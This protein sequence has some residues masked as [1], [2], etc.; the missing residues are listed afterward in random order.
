MGDSGTFSSPVADMTA[1]P[2]ATTMAAT[3][4]DLMDDSG[5]TG[6][7]E[8]TVT[9]AISPTSSSRPSTSQ[10]E[11]NTDT[12]SSVVLRDSFTDPGM[13]LTQFPMQHA[14]D[15]LPGSHVAM[16]TTE[17]D[18]LTTDQFVSTVML[19]STVGV[20]KNS[21]GS[22]SISAPVGVSR[23][24]EFLE[25]ASSELD[26][27]LTT[28]VSMPQ[29]GDS[30][31]KAVK[32]DSSVSS[33]VSVQSTHSD[34]LVIDPLS[35]TKSSSVSVKGIIQTTSLSGSS[36][37]QAH[38]S[39]IGLVPQ[40]SRPQP[41]ATSQ[42]LY[43]TYTPA[44]TLYTSGNTGLDTSFMQT[45]S[46][47]LPPPTHKPVQTSSEGQSTILG[48]G[49]PD[50]ILY[51][52]VPAIG[53]G[54][55]IFLLICII[56]ICR[57]KHK[58]S[59]SS[60]SKA[61]SSD[62]WVNH[63]QADITL[64]TR[65]PGSSL[66]DGIPFKPNIG[67]TTYE[68]VF[69]FNGSHG[70][71]L[72]LKQGDLV[73]VSRK[74]DN[75]WWQGSHGGMS[76]WFPSNY[77][78][79]APQDK[80]EED[81]EVLMHGEDVTSFN[82]G[83]ATPTNLRVSTLS[84][85]EIEAEPIYCK[86]QH[87]DKQSVCS[88]GSNRSSS[89]T[90]TKPEANHPGYA[91]P[92][93]QKHGNSAEHS[94]PHG[95]PYVAKFPFEARNLGE[96][97]IN[98]GD[99]IHCREEGKHGWIRGTNNN[100]NK[101]GWCPASYVEKVVHEVT[102]DPASY[103]QLEA[104]TDVVERQDLVGIVHH[105]IHSFDGEKAGDLQFEHG[106]YI[107][108]FQVLENGWW[109]GSK[110]KT[111]G[112]FPGSHVEMIDHPSSSPSPSTVCSESQG[113]L[114]TSHELSE[115]VQDI[116]GP[117]TPTKHK[118][119]RKAPP[120]PLKIVN[121]NFKPDNSSTTGNCNVNDQNLKSDHSKKAHAPDSKIPGL[122]GSKSLKIPRPKVAPPPPP[123]RQDDKPP[124]DDSVKDGIES[125][126][127]RID[128]D[129]E[130][131]SG[132]KQK[133]KPALP[134]RF[135][136]PKL[137][138]VP[139]GEVK[140]PDNRE[141]GNGDVKLRAPPP[142]KPLAPKLGPI[143]AKLSAPKSHED[144][145]QS[146]E[147]E[148]AYFH[149]T[150]QRRFDPILRQESSDDNIDR[151]ESPPYRS[152]ASFGNTFGK[153]PEEKIPI[154]SSFNHVPKEPASQLDMESREN[155]G[156]KN[157]ITVSEDTL[158]K[159]HDD[160]KQQEKTQI[161]KN[162]LEEDT[163]IQYENSKEKMK[164][165]SG[166]PVTPKMKPSKLQ[167]PKH[168][169]P[170]AHEPATSCEVENMED[171]RVQGLHKVPC[172]ESSDIP[173]S[174]SEESD[175]K[176]AAKE[177]DNM[178]PNEQLN[179]TDNKPKGEHDNE[180]KVSDERPRADSFGRPPVAPKP[181]SKGLVKPKVYSKDI[182]VDIKALSEEMTEKQDKQETQ[183]MVTV[184]KAKTPID[185]IP[186]RQRT[187]S[188]NESK[189]SSRGRSDSESESRLPLSSSKTQK[190]PQVRGR[191]SNIPS[192][193]IRNRSKEN[194][195][196]HREENE[197]GNSSCDQNKVDKSTTDVKS[198]T[199]SAPNDPDSLRNRSYSPAGRTGI[200]MSVRH[201]SNSP[202]GKSGIPPPG[203]PLKSPKQKS[204]ALVQPK[205]ITNGHDKPVNSISHNPAHG[206]PVAKS[207]QEMNEE[208]TQ[209]DSPSSVSKPDRPSKPSR[210]QGSQD[211]KPPKHGKSLLPVIHKSMEANVGSHNGVSS[212][213]AGTKAKRGI[214]VAKQKRSPGPKNSS[215][216]E[217]HSSEP[218]KGSLFQATK[219]YTAQNDGELT[220][221]AGT[222]VKELSDCDRAG[223]YVGMLADG[224]TGLYPG[225]HFQPSPVAAQSEA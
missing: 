24:S 191:K 123:I 219:S 138:T 166:I 97:T 98:K 117:S 211:G 113:S 161:L 186:N 23:S 147:E 45:S 131:I 63:A 73:Y 223:W 124:T 119:T 178:A 121:S 85:Q 165:K 212:P 64:T 188:E 75:G 13:D 118:P 21:G 209:N 16:T 192:P 107:T 154:F 171:N 56:C 199:V 217:N 103:Q 114:E 46:P 42:E 129:V 1:T 150:P 54:L 135:I 139:R 92:L 79:A 49:L 216:E 197:R 170:E 195:K 32:T 10:L 128:M 61:Q 7:E 106:D 48:H 151:A 162:E 214:P 225:N 183:D 133:V 127:A 136:K 67:C 196:V 93:Q 200:P 47:S 84:E 78:Q 38:S 95:I 105:A 74:E 99:L 130:D 30:I 213:S 222:F 9:M 153:P 110:D 20:E 198:T 168:S 164:P 70:N 44:Q 40:V 72:T 43:S 148:G 220:F 5:S 201:R 51:A 169:L 218:N 3:T 50:Y 158:S 146:E 17:K 205:K 149:I 111:V 66:E 109:L 34:F 194:S 206:E 132:S 160:Q 90:P 163:A 2:S 11:T 184:E 181:K 91:A 189:I 35:G 94:S 185:S 100:T 102:P 26:I 101:E 83:R 152:M 29:S 179:I 57:R 104:N 208:N 6:A 22:E 204:S 176:P 12:T 115:A 172:P 59:K 120:P 224:T 174:K 58:A 175:E 142:L 27:K 167:P 60:P 89:V 210:K 25:E 177:Q 88:Q 28:T 77:V 173:V 125:S 71:H 33:S 116:P 80:L 215:A 65:K 203:S 82:L 145:V 86:I 187:N 143:R 55:F 4:S 69:D 36:D 202:A 14:T 159:N 53:V 39:A 108:V 155:D 144:H 96:L 52:G 18:T 19:Y 87:K 62:M 137:V 156:S 180:V 8:S 141:V 15:Q 134:K 112:W 37:V 122:A 190:S 221:A 81:N 140:L 182:G 207:G 126:K 68:A 193:G 31:D 76:G 157:K 41:S